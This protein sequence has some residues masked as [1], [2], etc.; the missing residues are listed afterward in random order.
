MYLA[1][2]ISVATLVT[3]LK[4]VASGV[5][6]KGPGWLYTERDSLTVRCA[7]QLQLT[8]TPHKVVVAD[9]IHFQIY[10]S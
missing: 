3:N 6:H 7:S 4:S 8:E 1:N 5:V 10:A 9:Y 2:Y